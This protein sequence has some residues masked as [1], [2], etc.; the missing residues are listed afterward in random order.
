MNTTHLVSYTYMRRLQQAVMFVL[1]VCLFPFAAQALSSDKLT[2]TPVVIDAKAKPRDVLKESITITNTADHLLTL[3]PGVNNVRPEDGEQEFAA[4]QSS[5]DL[6]DSLANWIELSRGVIE[7]K[8]GEQKE[9]PFIVHVNMNAI[10]GVYHAQ[11][12]FSQG[13]TRAEAE[14]AGPLATVAVNLEVQED[15]KEVLQLGKFTTGKFF[16]AGDDVPKGE[17]Y[18]SFEAANG[19]LGFYIVSKGGPMAHRMRIR[20][21]SV[22]HFQ[23]LSPM[24]QGEK[25]GD[26][27]AALGSINVIAGELDR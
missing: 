7:L 21:P 6:D 15:T 11:I 10:T 3:Y 8:P 13:T 2:V 20:G 16:L 1:L 14:A 24:V 27:V 12:S 23:G 22:W 4:A 5:L 19:E 17:A 18:T 9:V 25:I 26:V